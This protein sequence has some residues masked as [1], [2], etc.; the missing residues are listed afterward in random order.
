MKKKEEITLVPEQEVA[1]DDF[2]EDKGVTAIKEL[3]GLIFPNI[4]EKFRDGRSVYGKAI[5]NYLASKGKK[6]KASSDRKEPY[7][8][9][10]EERDFIYN[11]CSTMK[12]S[13]MCETLYGG[14]INPSDMR[15]RACSAFVK[16]IDDK[17]VLSEV[18]RE[19]SPSDYLPP[20][21]ETKAISR[22]NKYVHEGIDKNNIKTSD[23]KNIA[24]LIAYMHTYRFLHQISNYASQD[25]RELFESSFVRYTHDKPDLTQEEVDQYI[26]LSAEV[27]IASNI[28]V[29][30]ERLQ[31]LLD[32]AAEETEGKRMAMSLVESINTAQT[33]YNQCVNR[34]TKLLNELK[35]KRSQR[36]SKQ[37]KENASILN[38]VEIWKDEESRH[39]MIKLA[40]IRKKALEEEVE[41]LST[42]DE[43]KCRIMGLTEE[44]VLNG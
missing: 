39:K 10:Q 11:N 1:V 5:K 31:E 9:N 41:R 21:T 42:M 32:Q 27:V 37:I 2:Y 15:F 8:L 16:S 24:K 26:V 12:V 43:I 18:V 35:E 28:Q 3:V 40:E 44:E 33:E 25:N 6:A 34:Q 38:L 29:R 4:D 7:D 13:D 22:I 36:L 14:K 23:K 30:V 17:V 19:V 20:K